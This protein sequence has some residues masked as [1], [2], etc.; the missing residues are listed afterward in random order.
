MMLQKYFRYLLAFLFAILLFQGCKKDTVIPPD[1]YYREYFTAEVGNFIVYQCDS[2]V[3]DDFN[4]TIDTFSFRIKEYYESEFVDNSGRSAIRTERYK[5][6]ESASNWVLKDVWQVVK[7]DLQVEKVEEDVRMIKLIFPVVDEK[8]WNINAL[9]DLG[10]RTVAY[11][12]IHS[13][14]ST[15]TLTFDSTITVENID[16][17]NLINEYRNT[18]IFAK[19]LGMVYKRF[20]DIQYVTPPAIGVESGVVFTMQAIE[21]GKE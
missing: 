20:V 1:P 21:F 15:E 4:G 10:V 11:K 19:G 13:P 5:Q 9:N 12:D 2:I 6:I 3:Y 14:Y 7:T 17:Q 8:E 18:E 16:P